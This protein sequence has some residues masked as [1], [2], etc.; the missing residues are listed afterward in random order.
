MVL[1]PEDKVKRKARRLARKAKATG[2]TNVEIRILEARAALKL[3]PEGWRYDTEKNVHISILLSQ[4]R[5]ALLS[6][7]PKSTLL[8]TLKKTQAIHLTEQKELEGAIRSDAKYSKD[9][10]GPDTLSREEIKCMSSEAY[11]NELAAR[12]AGILITLVEKW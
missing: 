3:A 9:H 11:G 10:H 7:S 1:T 2:P 4:I 6:N 5:R 8:S 12:A